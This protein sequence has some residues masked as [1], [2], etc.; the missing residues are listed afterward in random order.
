MSIRSS[1]INLLAIGDPIIDTHVQIDDDC[2][3]CRVLIHSDQKKL[4]LDYGTKIPIIDSFQELGGNAPNVAVGATKLGLSSALVST[5]GDD[6]NGRMILEKLKHYGVTSDYITFDAGSKTRY[7]IVLNHRGERTI[8]SYSDKKDYVWP[9]PVA[10]TQWVY[11]TGMSEGF[12]TVQN[13]L[14]EYL[15]KHQAA[16]L[17]VNP[18]S[19]MLKY[20]LTALREIIARANVL[21]VNLEEAERILG[22]T[23]EKEKSVMALIHELCKL[24]PSEIAL[25][26][27]ERGA[28]AGTAEEVWQI[29]PFPV[30]VVSKTGAGDAFSAGYLAARY[31][32]HDFEHALLWGTAN[33]SGVVQAH[34]PHAG[35]QTKAGVEKM[36]EKFKDIKPVLVG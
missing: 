30:K 8:L 27:G 36:I 2:S 19:Y 11:Y 15:N 23:L 26:D 9:A 33:S 31:Y 16:H 1:M 17:A 20:A 35:L 5:I 21:I 3:E 28:W 14:V 32:G 12:E 34:G 13:K 7:S 25:T 6:A 18:G 4:C 10:A 24:G 29:S 22:T